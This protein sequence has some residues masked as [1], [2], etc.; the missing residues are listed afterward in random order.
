[1]KN[2]FFLFCLM[3]V[4]TVSCAK[5]QQEVIQ[6]VTD[7]PVFH[8]TIENAGTRVF[9]DDQLRVLWNADDRVSIFNK[10][11][12][13]RQYR[14]MG[15]DGANAGSFTKVPSDD[16]VTSN[17]LEY[18]YS[19]YP[20]NENTCISN[21]G[22][23]TVYLPA[24]QTYREDSFGLGANTMIA[25]TEDDELMFKN[26]CG[27][28][29]VKL[30]GDNVSVKSIT[31]KGND[32]ELL[33]GKA[34]VVASIDEAPALTFDT[35]V[36]SEMITLTPESPVTIGSTE[37]TA[38]TFWFVVPPTTFNDGITLSVTDQND[39]SFVKTTTG[40]LVISRNR[41][42]NTAALKVETG[43]SSGDDK[44]YERISE[45]RFVTEGA[46][47]VM[48]TAADDLSYGLSATQGSDFR[49]G[50]PVTKSHSGA[51]AGEGVETIVN[52]SDDVEVLTVEAGTKEGVYA[53]K[54]KAGKYLAVDASKSS[55]LLSIDSKT[56]MSDWRIKYKDGDCSFECVTPSYTYGLRYRKND[57]K[58][59]A[60]RPSFVAANQP[61][62]L[63]KLEGSGGSDWK[64]DP[65]LHLSKTSLTLTEGD[66]QR[67]AVALCYSLSDG[68]VVTFRSEDPSVATVSDKGDVTAVKEGETYI[69]A[70]V[71]ETENYQADSVSCKVTVLPPVPVSSVTFD[72]TKMTIIEGYTD[73]LTV[74]VSPSNA[75]DK[76][77]VWSISDESVISLSVE[78]G[79]VYAEKP[80]TATITATSV[81]D[82][83]KKAT[84]TVT[85]KPFVP[86]TGV[87]LDQSS[88]RM[89]KGQTAK[90]TATVQPSDAS[91]VDY[92]WGS[93]NTSVADVDQEGNVI[94]KSDILG[95]SCN[96][97]VIARNKDKGNEH[98]ASCKVT[99]GAAPVLKLQIAMSM[100]ETAYWQDY[101][102]PFQL[103]YTNQSYYLRLYDTAN[104]RIVTEGTFGKE[105]AMFHAGHMSSDTYTLETYTS[106]WR[107]VIRKDGF[108]GGTVTYKD[109]A[110]GI[111]FSQEVVFYY[112]RPLNLWL[113]SY[114]V[115]PSGQKV[116]VIAGKTERLYIGHADTGEYE[117][118]DPTYLS[119]TGGDASIA[120]VSLASNNAD[121]LISAKKAGET[122]WR[123]Q[124]SHYGITLDRT[125]TVKVKTRYVLYYSN[126]EYTSSE[127]TFTYDDNETN[128][129]V[130]QV[131]DNL[132]KQYVYTTS[133]LS[134][135]VTS[136]SEYF[137]A[138][139]DFYG[140]SSAPSG[141]YQVYKVKAVKRTQGWYIGNVSFYY[142]GELLK[143]V[144]FRANSPTYSLRYSTSYS[145]FSASSPTFNNALAL[146]KG[147]STYFRLY[148]DTHGKY[149]TQAN[150]Y[151]INGTSQYISL[152][153]VYKGSYMGQV[154]VK[155][156]GVASATVHIGFSDSDK[157]FSYT[158]YF[159]SAC[160]AAFTSY[161]YE[162][163]LS[164]YQY[165]FVGEED[166]YWLF[167]K[168]ANKILEF[169]N[170]CM[171]I[172]NNNP[173]AMSVTVEN[174]PV[175]NDGNRY[176]Q[177]IVF[178]AKASGNV[179]VT[180]TYNDN[181]GTQASTTFF[182]TV[183]SK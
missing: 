105:A 18:V 180:L 160:E 104:S 116:E 21:D 137:S 99:I 169:F 38:T 141:V 120:E 152:E 80:G 19:V 129:Y 96:I 75:A 39:G 76:K 117:M 79:T 40:S 154:D 174:R 87:S 114:T 153:N 68:G 149:V 98:S 61:I 35:A 77:L 142:A 9:A 109:E 70:R 128:T 31:L 94:A 55:A 73:V 92:F 24:E 136:G 171:T 81:M 150:N 173:T 119:I 42:K 6:T 156:G 84:C 124:Y 163:G 45:A 88:L 112:P 138:S 63:Y 37:E 118:L 34:T 71:G 41:L 22:E 60:F 62:A 30:Y 1:M 143:T 178:K 91:N 59:L 166:V 123:V 50:V 66:T 82:P 102:G 121:I 43:S 65:D 51:K 13:N 170:D 110:Q 176:H 72:K 146:T 101:T 95:I 161:W 165:P 115:L 47:F 85:V 16:F 26:L 127:F 181:N 2:R 148:D 131:Y 139:I 157:E 145:S 100:L 182:Y 49:L 20:Y 177:C 83:T 44:V 3:A 130:F 135:N 113:D 140:A 134:A 151:H 172:E 97:V 158:K 14:F 86:V 7:D 74:T 5:E 46:Q 179:K 58:F 147:T 93:D 67:L 106:F 52:P 133:G 175:V 29:A 57:N 132:N 11:T 144:K 33:S 56:T 125:F 8:A 78:S 122:T 103:S 28:F 10:T 12:F 54:T 64:L 25:I 162:A 69:W 89:Q 111:N 48:A 168:D 4:M 90:L 32:N 27:Y 108:F 107:V 17:P 183:K 53:F 126:S 159:Y 164:Y 167:N 23:I 15:E 155:V 36:A